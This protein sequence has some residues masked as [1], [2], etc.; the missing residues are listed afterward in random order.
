MMSVVRSPSKTLEGR[1]TGGSQPDL[2]KI[3]EYDS[4]LI[5]LR[6]RKQPDYESE[7]RKEVSEIRQDIKK[8][9]EICQSQRDEVC[10]MKADVSDIK[11]KLINLKSTTENIILEHTYFKT[12]LS[13]F[14]ESFNFHS[15]RQ[16]ALDSRVET[17][18]INI[19]RINT[20][21][22]DVSSLKIA[23]DNLLL[24]NYMLQQRERL[25]NLE[26]SGIPERN[27]E[28]LSKCVVDMANAVG[29]I[30]TA[31]NI[32]RVN[33]VQPRVKVAGKPRNVVV[34]LTSLLIKDSILSGI[35]K[36]KGITTNEIGLPGEPARI[37]VN[38]HLI[39]FY[40]KLRKETKIAAEAANYKH[41][42]VR[43]CR[44]FA[45]KTDTSTIIYVRDVS[46][47]QLLK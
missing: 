10:G 40:K 2:S 47:L 28:N 21:E 23:H 7:M 44:I 5:T 4:S 34:Q 42:W 19:N 11:D 35:R 41:V 14:K 1:S 46:D 38:E 12:E 15:Q 39:P 17:I 27:S 24:E 8:L 20:V 22:Q 25:L 6:K 16:D 37:Y 26:I 43:D 31:D 33:R 36:K 3:T 18:E 30:I 9:M 45:R 29:V 13:D 32:T